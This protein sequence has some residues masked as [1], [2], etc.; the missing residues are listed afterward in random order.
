[1][2]D[3]IFLMLPGATSQIRETWCV[4][5]FKFTGVCYEV[6]ETGNSQCYKCFLLPENVN[7]DGVKQ[8]RNCYISFATYIKFF[9]VKFK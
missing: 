2:G 5:S 7:I 6:E 3:N 8:R 1:M 9:D 4:F